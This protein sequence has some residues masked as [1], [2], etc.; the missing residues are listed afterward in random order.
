MRIVVQVAMIRQENPLAAV[1]P[2]VWISVV[3]AIF[4]AV[5]SWTKGE[6]GSRREGAKKEREI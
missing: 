6:K 4:P 1:R 2:A 3:G 5:R